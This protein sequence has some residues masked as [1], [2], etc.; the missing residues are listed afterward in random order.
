[1]PAE[2]VQTPAGIN[3][4]V[5]HK[6]QVRPEAPVSSRVFRYGAWLLPRNTTLG[7]VRRR[8]TYFLGGILN[9]KK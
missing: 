2:T 6:S 5:P 7:P 9:E 4:A 1:V 3:K 8:L